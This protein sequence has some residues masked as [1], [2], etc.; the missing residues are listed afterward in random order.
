MIVAFTVLAFV[1]GLLLGSFANVVIYRVPAGMSVVKPRSRCPQC[2]TPIHARH[3]VPVL[4]W[5]WLRGKCA[6]CREPISIRYPV[7]ELTAGVAFALIVGLS[8]LRWV[9]LLLLV[10]AIFSIIL[11]AIDLDVGR[12]PSAI[13]GPLAITTAVVI[14]LGS[15]FTDSWGIALRALLGALAVGLLYLT[16]HLIYPSGLGFGDV[17]LAPVIGAILGVFGWGPVVVGTFA[18]F[19]WGALVGV[20][21]MIATGRARK[22]RIPF[23]PWMLAGAWTG[24]IWGEPVWDWYLATMLGA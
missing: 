13:V 21:V 9:T 14:A 23:G 4:G 24:V 2:E 16:A 1:L 22:V 10:F 5:L 6:S 12:L 20:V 3:N 19:L 15:G 7:V 11:A 8:G 17:Q 18:G